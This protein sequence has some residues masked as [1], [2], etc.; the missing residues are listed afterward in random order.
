LRKTAYDIQKA[1]SRGPTGPFLA[2]SG[3]VTVSPWIVT[4]D[5]LNESRVLR[6]LE[7]IVPLEAHL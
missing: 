5:A 1:K 4:L 3:S 2:K 7:A 6:S